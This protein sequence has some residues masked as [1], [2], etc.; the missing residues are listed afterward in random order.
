MFWSVIRLSIC[1]WYSQ[2]TELLR[3]DRV[4][5]RRISRNVLIAGL[6]VYTQVPLLISFQ[7]SKP[8]LD[9]YT[10]HLY[11]EV[12]IMNPPANMNR[13]CGL[14]Y[15][16]GCKLSGN[17]VEMFVGARYMPYTPVDAEHWHFWHFNGYWYSTVRRTI[18]C[19][20]T[21]FCIETASYSRRAL[22]R[23]RAGS[24]IILDSRRPPQPEG[25]RL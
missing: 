4:V 1:V 9:R 6:A 20:C 18:R 3:A 25:L 22:A 17:G 5:R 10:N 13:R 15:V 2:P 7:I 23:G 8:A 11:A 12:P 19:T 21:R 16:S 24:R 14:N